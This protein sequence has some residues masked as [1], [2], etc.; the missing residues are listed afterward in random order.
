MTAAARAGEFCR[1]SLIQGTSPDQSPETVV[2]ACPLILQRFLTR[3]GIQGVFQRSPEKHC[4][5]T[6]L[7]EL[8]AAYAIFNRSGDRSGLEVLPFE[9]G[10]NRDQSPLARSSEQHLPGRS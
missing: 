10:T 7:L 3:P 9:I 6:L 2:L 1:K 4:E 5:T 8:S